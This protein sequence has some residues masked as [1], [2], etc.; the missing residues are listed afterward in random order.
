MKS[1]FILLLILVANSSIAQS[2][3]PEFLR[4]NWRVENK[5]VYEHWDKLNETNMKGF[6]FQIKDGQMA[7]TEYLDITQK[8]DEI[9]YTVSVINQNKGKAIPFQMIETDSTYTFENLNH[10]FPKKVIY[11]KLSESEVLVNVSDGGSKRFLYKMIRQDESKP[12]KD[13][14]IANPDYS[15][16]LAGKWGG[17]EYG[18]KAYIFV[19]LKTGANKST[20]QSFINETFKGHLNNI[21]KLVNEGK[22]IVAGPFD[23][24][25]QNYRGIFI[26][27]NITTATEAKE[28]LQTDPAIQSGL[29]DFD[30]YSWYGSAAL[31]AYIPVSEK[32]WKLKP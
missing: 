8:G 2:K 32:I 15:R 6:S 10:D 25:D 9:T 4:G 18:M 7:I 31:P 14:T 5:E 20:D 30:L 24:N 11:K 1:V 19:I 21:Q 12:K 26:L 29:L 16:Y 17:D 28:L 3:L 23:K 13:S 27:D 22:V